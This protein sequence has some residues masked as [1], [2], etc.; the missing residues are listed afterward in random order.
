MATVV[1]V[2]NVDPESIEKQIKEMFSSIP[3]KEVKGYRTYPLTY[4]PG[5]ELY[6]I[7]DDLERS[8][9]LELMIPHPCVIGNTIGSIYQK[10]LG[11]LL[12]RAISN[13]L[14]Y[15]NIRCNVSDAWFL[16]DKNHLFLLF[17][18]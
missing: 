12:I 15:Q 2:G 5:V 3:R 1:V 9:E 6:E 11:S 18:G 10:E 8:S 4:D 16:S 7:G 13:R 17:P 14:K